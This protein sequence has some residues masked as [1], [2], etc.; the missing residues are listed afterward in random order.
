VQRRVFLKTGAAATLTGLVAPH[1]A[2]STPASDSHIEI[3]VEEPIATI[4]P[5]IYGHFI[6]HIGGVIYDGVWV[7]KQSKI[8]NV[9]GIRKSLIDALR[10]IQAPM[11]RWP[12]GCF[13]D[14]YDWRDGI[15]PD[16][17][18]RTNFWAEEFDPSQLKTKAPQVYDNNAFG[19]DEFLRFCHLS[20]VE[21][22]LAA[23]VR[24]LSPLDFDRWVEY[25]NSPSGT[26]TLADQR[27]RNGS[28]APYNVKLWGIGNES[29]GCGGNFTP[30]DY[31]TEFRRFTSWVPKY[32]L[33][34]QYIASGPSDNDL[35]WT[36]GFFEKAFSMGDHNISGWSIHHYAWNLS[37]GKSSDWVA[38]KG[39]SL[40]FDL[41]DWYEVFKQGYLIEKIIQDQWAAI[42]E[43][44][45]SHQIKLVVDEYGPWYKKG[46]EVSPDAILSQQ[47]T[48]RDALFTAF[49][50][51]VFNR[52]ADKVSMAACAQ[53]INCI[54]ALFLAHED[55]LVLTPNYHVFQMYAAHQGAQSLRTEITSPQAKYSSDGEPAT[56]WGLNGSAS[57]KGKSLTLTVVNADASSPREAEILVRGATVSSASSKVLAAPD[58]H[59][60]NSFEQSMVSKPVEQPV[61]QSGGNSLHL[62]FKQ[63]SVTAVTV[64]LV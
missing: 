61:R 60:H 57:L 46:T 3:L 5:N 10:E 8:A 47:V 14:S 35:V 21:P 31:A 23:N 12:G 34:L 25:C 53:L 16:R 63:A 29:W 54:N 30:Q 26:T 13:A 17:P 42:G 6:E 51:D 41:V 64:N 18:R 2:M 27:A 4:S 39:D 36:K 55:K 32:S 15:G 38:A 24:S 9:S 50:L 43:Y 44:D 59:A 7:G 48:I 1:I 52:H 58:I 56:F 28:S 20:G 22:Y 45:E 62:T 49:T 40:K 19:T 11:V 37:R 33:P